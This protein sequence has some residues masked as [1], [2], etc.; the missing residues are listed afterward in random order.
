MSHFINIHTHTPTSSHIEPQGVGIHPW[1]A[2]E[3][4]FDSA[5]FHGAELIGEIGLDYACDV[6][7]KIQEDLFCKQLVLAK[8]MG[9]PV[10][11]HSVR[12]FE[13]VLKLL[14]KYKLEKVVFH[15]FIGSVEQAK[16]AVDKGYFLSFGFT[17]ERSPKT[18]AALR[19]IPLSNIFAETDTSSRPIEEAYEMICRIKGHACP[20]KRGKRFHRN[21]AFA[22]RPPRPSCSSR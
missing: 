5:M 18:I 2:E 15:G 21:K 3:H 6:D 22:P 7:K 13:D 10:V 9:L 17:A 16:R 12:A 1:Q 4:P 20:W 11:I 8:E 19:A 14:L